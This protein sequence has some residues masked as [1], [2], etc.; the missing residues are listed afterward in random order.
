M[1]RAASGQSSAGRRCGMEAQV[2]KGFTNPLTVTPAGPDHP[3]AFSSSDSQSWSDWVATVPTWSTIDRQAGEAASSSPQT[4]G[5]MPSEMPKT[6]AVEVLARLQRAPTDV[7]A[8][9][10]ERLEVDAEQRLGGPQLRAEGRVGPARKPLHADQGVVRLDA[11]GQLGLDTR[12][13][14]RRSTARPRTAAARRPGG[15]SGTPRRGRAGPRRAGRR[16]PRPC[17][18][19]SSRTARPSTRGASWSPAPAR[20]RR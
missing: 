7:V 8:R 9:R 20:A 10:P 18:P 1:A 12:S 19:A 17:P 5:T 15:R 6:T 11:L 16:S 13:R 4:C 3:S 2:S 14:W